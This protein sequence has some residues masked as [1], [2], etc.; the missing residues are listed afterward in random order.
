MDTT[1][2][3]E[4]VDALNWLDDLRKSVHGLSEAIGIANQGASQSVAGLAHAGVLV[5]ADIAAQIDI[6]RSALYAPEAAA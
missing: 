1:V 6:I 5:A 3:V 4:V 2:P